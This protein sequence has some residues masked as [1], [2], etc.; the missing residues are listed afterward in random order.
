MAN[1]EKALQGMLGLCQRAGKL[2]S[3]TDIALTAL[4]GGKGRLILLDEQASENTMKKVTDA[5]IYYHAPWVQLPAGLLGA[6]TGKD[7]RMA[8]AVT[9]AGFAARLQAICA[10]EDSASHKQKPT[11]S[12]D[13]GVQASNDEG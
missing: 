9:D 6:A 10:E 2:Q 3:G 1:K 5:C 13:P 11:K 8:A 4:R 7:G 12:N